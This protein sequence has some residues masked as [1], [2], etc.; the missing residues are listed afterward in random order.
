RALANDPPL[1]VADEPTG[2]LDS[3]TAEDV[4]QLFKS[5][6]AKGRTMIMVTHSLDLAVR[7]SRVVEIRDGRI[8]N[9]VP[10]T[11]HPR[12]R[13]RNGAQQGISEQHPVG[14]VQ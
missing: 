8:T 7:G 12:A 13:N 9:D 1:I 11:L 3:T 10:A 2:N 14:S 4:F 6:I 5:L